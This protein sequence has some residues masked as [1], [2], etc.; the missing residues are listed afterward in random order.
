MGGGEARVLSLGGRLTPKSSLA[1]DWSDEV[2]PGVSREKRGRLLREAID[3]AHADLQS[4]PAARPVDSRA[5]SARAE[6][7]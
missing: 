4:G 7:E 6:S 5:E 3:R 2:T 1:T